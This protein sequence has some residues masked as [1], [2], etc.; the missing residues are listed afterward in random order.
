MGSSDKVVR[1]KT[2]NIFRAARKVR[3]FKQSDMAQSLGITQGMVSKL[4]SATLAPDAGLWYD[5]CKLLG[6]DGD[7]TYTSGYLFTS[8]INEE[9]SLDSFN[10]GKMEKSTLIK[11]KE[12]IP[13][14][15]TIRDMKLMDDFSTLLKKHQIDID[16]FTV[17]EYQV[18][19]NLLAL[20]FDFLNENLSQIKYMNYSSKYFA[21][22]FD[23]FMSGVD[24]SIDKLI[25]KL[26]YLEQIFEYEKNKH[27][28]TISLSPT[29]KYSISDDTFVKSY[30]R[31]KAQLLK[32][33]CSNIYDLKNIKLYKLDPLNYEIQYTA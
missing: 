23:Y 25:Q 5:F 14:I 7:L 12:C 22:D 8:N 29:F 32:T 1:E 27:S 21:N 13:F 10:I 2:A 9:L 28:L 4:E 19:M 31:Y 16:V 30:M 15:H 24:S 6:V 17:P 11:V 18:P 26:Q 20:I 33:V 3:G